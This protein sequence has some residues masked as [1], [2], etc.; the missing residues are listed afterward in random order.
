MA[1]IGFIIVK[2]GHNR[3]DVGCALY[4]RLW[5]KKKQ[6]H[7]LGGFVFSNEN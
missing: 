3:E 5:C 6:S 2:G 4:Q 1:A 7:F